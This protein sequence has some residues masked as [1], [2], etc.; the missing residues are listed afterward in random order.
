MNR[1][2]KNTIALLAIS[3]LL[4]GC[5]PGKEF[6]N[7]QIEGA[8]QGKASSPLLLKA[9]I[10]TPDAAEL[11]LPVYAT[12]S[13][14][15]VQNEANR[16][17]ENAPFVEL[18]DGGT[19]ERLWF[20]SSR[21]T[22]D[23]LKNKA[24]NH[25][26]QIYYS[27]RTLGEGK[28][29]TEGWGNPVRFTVEG[30][31]PLTQQFNAAG[32]GA[33]TVANGILILSCDQLEAG[34]STE[35]KNLWS[36]ETID[37]KYSNPKPLPTLS[38]TNTW[39]SQPALSSDG[40]H[41]FFVSNRK[42]DTQNLTYSN[43]S[44]GTDLNIFYSFFKDG[45]WQAP[46]IV[47]EL[48]S[49]KNETTPHI[50][51]V[52]NKLYFASDR[53]GDFDIYEIELTLDSNEGG[54]K[55]SGSPVLFSGNLV[56]VCGSGPYDPYALNGAHDQTYPFLYFNPRNAK[57]PRAL[58]WSSNLPT[59]Y[60]GYDL[61]ASAMPYKVEVIAQLKDKSG[62]GN[63]E[64][65]LPVIELSGAKTLQMKEERTTFQLWSHLP[66]QI[67]GGSAAG[68]QNG[69]HICDIHPQFIFK[70]YKAYDASSNTISE[71]GT[72][73]NGAEVKSG[74]TAQ[75]G[76]LPLQN[77]FSDTTLVDEIWITKAWDRKPACPEVLEIPQK[78]RAIAYFQ[79]GFWE[80][81]SSENLK[82][83]L[84]LLHQGYEVTPTGD[85]YN[86]QGKI[87]FNGSDYVVAGW[88][89]LLYPVKPEETRKY[90][91]ANA[92]WIE[93]HPDNY[94]WGDRPG[95]SANIEE[96]MKG[97]K[98]RIQEYVEFADKVDENLKLLTDTIKT[99]YIHF[100]DMHKENKP[101]LLIEI[102]AVSDQREILRGWYIGDTIAYRGSEYLGNNRFKTEPVKIIPPKVNEKTKTV[103]E[104]VECSINLNAQGNNGSK[105]G[106]SADKTE[107][108]TNLSRLRAWFGYKE[109]YNRLT[110]SPEFKRMLDLGK[111]ALPDNNVSYDDADIIIITRG[112]RIDVIDPKNPY[113]AVN[114]P[115][116]QGFYDYDQVRRVEV[117]IRLL[118]D[119]DKETRKDFCCE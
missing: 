67:K 97:R 16:F 66:Y 102:F 98:Q 48:F 117:R 41:L 64:L 62:V 91:I 93:L 21:A 17:K 106:I 111:V 39:E 13:Y 25:Y 33:A 42:I 76:N 88:G 31:S 15:L 3:A 99:A 84:K 29:P 28:C 83:D 49:P 79:T 2:Y 118:M 74:L 55:I 92:R 61:Y 113:P 9:P 46:Q 60:G 56:E 18:L 26:Q 5:R 1:I 87:S 116:G 23:Y 78:H 24:T 103:E 12:G 7:K 108:N 11:N 14:F 4:A 19:R 107:L 110:D 77:I 65:D 36:L 45:E 37:G 27:E 34:Q 112:R 35:F 81:N 86:P 22:D 54:Y 101:K 8:S 20:S 85:I 89:D 114:N 63:S 73:I 75:Y 10:N 96:R 6:A 53:K 82:R 68:T 57:M 51:A 100:L 43:D 80:V 71:G 72:L 38:N 115:N 119:K 105:L 109:V 30:D 90:S 94:N 32:K 70:G 58:F 59:G 104:I 95:F 47:A 40:K 44:S 69:T 50:S 52:G